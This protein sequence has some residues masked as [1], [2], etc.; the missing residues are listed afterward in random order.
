MSDLTTRLAGLTMAGPLMTAAGC[1]GREL[2]PFTDLAALGALVTRTLTLDPSGGRPVPRLVETP[3]G[4]LAATGCPNPGLQ[5]FLATELPWFAQRRIRTVVSVTGDT[6]AEHGELARRLGT[7]PGVAAVEVRLTTSSVRETAAVVD[8][9]RQG[10]PA[11]IPLLAK[12]GAGD[13]VELAS[14]AADHGADAVVLVQGFPALALDPRTLAPVLGG[15]GLLSGPATHA[16][17]L[18]CVYDVHAA[19]P[20]VPIV[21]V[22]GVRTGRD[23]LAMLAAGATAV[24]LGS[25]LFTDPSAP[26]RVT[27][28][29]VAELDA[30]HL[31]SA[32][33][34]VG[35]AHQH[36]P[37]GDRR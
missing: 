28:E 35:L 6:P 12:T 37:E 2:A 31:A 15:E 14:A 20:S 7:S 36:T 3:S 16:L 21:G 5:G 4:V 22:G 25:V 26:Q 8:A 9:V 27:A 10:L 13:V 29:L 24:Q 11:G 1:G 30:R 19:L 23:A 18:R 32:A 17:A 34:A 33:D